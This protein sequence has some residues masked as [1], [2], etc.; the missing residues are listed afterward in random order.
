[1]VCLLPGEYADV[2]PTAASGG[3]DTT[4]YADYYYQ[5]TG[6]RIFHRSGNSYY[7]SNCGVFCSGANDTSSVSNDGIGSR[8]GFYG[9]INVYDTD[10]WKAL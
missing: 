2:M 8:L 10:A 7:G 4:Y 1:M 9:T 6:N 3:S 5:N